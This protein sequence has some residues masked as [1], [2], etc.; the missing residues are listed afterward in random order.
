LAEAI[1]VSTSALKEI[2]IAEEWP[3][4]AVAEL[5]ARQARREALLGRPD[6]LAALAEYE[7]S[8]AALQLE[9]ARQYPDVH[10]GTGYQYDQGENKWS[11]GVSLELPVLNHNEGPLA[12]AQAKRSEAAAH[13]LNVQ[14]KVMAEIDR[15]VTA[16][17]NAQERLNSLSTLR[18]TQREHAG[19]MSAQVDAGAAEPLDLL[20]LQ[21]E[22]AATDLLELEARVQNIV[23]MGQ[24]EEAIQRPLEVAVE[25]SPR[26]SAGVKS[27]E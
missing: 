3:P 15:A 22:Q 27:S 5:T 12:E 16:Y 13:F 11:L 6:V 10:L 19:V 20:A 23:A 21:A 26:A 1:G 7:A 4:L 24:L 17:T 8:Q 18:S 9:V 14:A 25:Q 2:V